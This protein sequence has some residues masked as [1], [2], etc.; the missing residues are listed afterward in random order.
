MK[1]IKKKIF[2]LSLSLILLGAIAIVP[3]QAGANA[4]LSLSPSTKTVGIGETFSID[5]LVN[6]NSQNVVA[7]GAYLTYDATKL[8][9]IDIDTSKSILTMEAEKIFDS[10]AGKIKISRTKPTPG[11]N[12][13]NGNV[14]TI[15]F[16]ALSPASPTKVDFIIDGIGI[17]GTDS[18]ILLDDGKGT[19]ILSSVKNGSYTITSADIVPPVCI[20]NADPISG[21]APLTVSFSTAGSTDP[22]GTITSNSWNFGDSSPATGGPNVKHTYTAAGTYTAVLSLTDNDGATSSCSEIIAVTAPTT[23]PA[24]SALIIIGILAATIYFAYKK[25]WVPSGKATKE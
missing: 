22:D 15:N 18:D 9:V 6:T 3:A 14:A 2:A 23:G 12:T 25:G 8:Q 17:S 7:V 19:D 16:K 11:I 21:A 4:E 10:N 1:S 13:A 24:T 20:I 5:V